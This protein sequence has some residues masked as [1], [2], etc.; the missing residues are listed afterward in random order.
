MSV[1]EPKELFPLRKILVSTDGS[2]NATRAENVAVELA[3]QYGA[4]L[5]VV[6]VVAELVPSFYSPIGVSTPTLD[7]S[8]YFEIAESEGKKIV[9]R[10]VDAA[11]KQSVN[12][13]GEVLKTGASVVEAILD[14]SEKENVDLIVIGTR[15]LGGFKKLVLGSVSSGVVSHASCSV[16]VVR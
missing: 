6:Y 5:I 9:N 3:K 2:E 11:G 7:Y 14:A 1:N 8:K 15:G 16:L 4:E 12:V 13:K 10:V